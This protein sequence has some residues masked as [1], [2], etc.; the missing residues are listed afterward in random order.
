MCRS[1]S[2]ISCRNGSE[3][4]PVLLAQ[5][6]T[7]SSDDFH[8]NAF[9]DRTNEERHLHFITQSAT[10]ATTGDQPR[11]ASSRLTAETNGEGDHTDGNNQD[12]SPQHIDSEVI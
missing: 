3:V 6:P 12:D 11:L 10:N 5:V 1:L 9:V 8:L 4:I 2:F 7:V